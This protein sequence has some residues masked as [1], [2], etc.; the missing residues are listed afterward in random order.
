MHIGHAG[1]E[2]AV[3]VSGDQ[4]QVIDTVLGGF[5][6]RHHNAR[7]HPGHLHGLQHRVAGQA[8][9]LD[10]VVRGGAEH[11]LV[12]A[13][14]DQRHHVDVGGVGNVGGQAVVLGGLPA[15]RRAGVA[16]EQ[17]GHARVVMKDVTDLI[18]DDLGRLLQPDA[19][20]AVEDLRQ[21]GSRQFGGDHGGDHADQPERQHQLALDAPARNGKGAGFLAGLGD[22]QVSLIAAAMAGSE[23][24][25]R[26]N[27][28][29]SL[30]RPLT[31]RLRWRKNTLLPWNSQPRRSLLAYPAWPHSYT[32]I[33]C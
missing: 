10:D 27:S 4:Q 1:E 21:R 26:I 18:L 2:T 20:V 33:L 9:L 23:R 25:G 6:S 19:H 29:T 12:V 30:S 31:S 5:K 17:L 22:H 32:A 13:H 15:R 8:D 16:Q 11:Q 7:A 14:T 3:Q 24:S 28:F